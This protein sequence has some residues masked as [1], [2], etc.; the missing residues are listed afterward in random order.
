MLD[1]G[2]AEDKD[3]AFGGGEVEDAGG[4][5]CGA[6][7]GAEDFVLFLFGCYK[8]WFFVQGAVDEDGIKVRALRGA[9]TTSAGMPMAWSFF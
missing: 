8:I 1:A 2:F 5:D 4:V 6:V 3:G 7:G 9:R